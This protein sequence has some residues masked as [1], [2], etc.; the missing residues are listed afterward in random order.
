MNEKEDLVGNRYGRLLVV[1]RVEAPKHLKYR[2]G[3][4]YLCECDCGNES[5]VYKYRLMNGLTGSCGCYKK[6]KF[7]VFKDLIGKKFGRLLIIKRE[8]NDSFGAARFLC[9]CDCGNEKIIRSHDLINGKTIS[10]GCYHKKIISLE[11]GKASLNQVYDRYKRSS[12]TKNIIFSLSKDEFFEI[13]QKNCFY[14]GSEPS[15]IQKNNWKTGDFIYNGIDRIDNRKGY[16]DDNVVTCCWKCN[17]AKSKMN[18]DEFYEWSDRI[19]KYRHINL[20]KIY[21]E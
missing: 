19:Y 5:I 20:N 4:Y 7:A 12:K 16:I 2:K 17:Q 6:E 9:K 18:I 11:N 1:K 21:G 15:N 10:C 13:T 8:E 3:I 14:C